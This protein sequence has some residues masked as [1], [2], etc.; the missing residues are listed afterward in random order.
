MTA[1]LLLT[2]LAYGVPALAQERAPVEPERV[3]VPEEAFR[4]VLGRHPRGV[5]ISEAELAELIAKGPRARREASSP[6]DLG[7]ARF[8]W[9]PSGPRW[10]ESRSPVA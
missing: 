3:Y 4:E 5:L 7:R 1:A 6:W 10:S 8:R 9:R 2:A